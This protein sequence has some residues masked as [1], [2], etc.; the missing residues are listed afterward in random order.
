MGIHSI[1]PMNVFGH[2]TLSISHLFLPFFAI[3]IP[4]I[5]WLSRKSYNKCFSLFELKLNEKDFYDESV[6]KLLKTE[7]SIYF[8]S[9]KLKLL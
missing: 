7:K 2:S 4:V 5:D 6:F 1:I 3:Y 8:Y 9:I